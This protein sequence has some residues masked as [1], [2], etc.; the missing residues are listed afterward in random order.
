MIAPKRK[1][2]YN[3]TSADDDQIIHHLFGDKILST[4]QSLETLKDT[5]RSSRLLYRFMGDIFILQR[6][7][8]LFQELIIHPRL[9]KQLFAEFENDLSIIQAHTRHEGVAKVLEICQQ[10]LRQLRERI[11]SVTADQARIRRHL[12]RGP[13]AGSDQNDSTAGI[14]DYPQRGR[15]GPH[16]RGYPINTGLRHDQYGKTEHHLSH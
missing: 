5:G 8:F 13:G 15:Y 7:A 3:Y 10:T 6:N 1:I 4:L 16:R 11:R 2:P 12:V 9:R 14:S